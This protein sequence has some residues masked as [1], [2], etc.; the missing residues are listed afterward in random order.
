MD[1]GLEGLNAISSWEDG[2]KGRE[3]QSL[4]V[5]GINELAN[6]VRSIGIQ[7]KREGE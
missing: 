7:F 4:D 1:D 3:F 5:I 6:C 2:R